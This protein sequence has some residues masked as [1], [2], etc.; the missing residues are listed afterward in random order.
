[1]LNSIALENSSIMQSAENLFSY[2]VGSQLVRELVHSLALSRFQALKQRLS[3]G[4]VTRIRI[5][6]GQF[7]FQVHKPYT[8]ICRPIIVDFISWRA[9]AEWRNV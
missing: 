2:V 4:N 8:R 3:S 7:K 5:L 9:L 6:N 1:M